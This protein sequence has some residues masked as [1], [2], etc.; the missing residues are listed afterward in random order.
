MPYQYTISE[1]KAF[2]LN[3][4]NHIYTS[5]NLNKFFHGEILD[6]QHNLVKST[7]RHK[8]M[9]GIFSTS[10]TQRFGKNKKGNIIYIQM[11]NQWFLF[12]AETEK[13]VD[14]NKMK[15]NINS[16]SHNLKQF[17]IGKEQRSIIFNKLADFF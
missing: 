7:I 1:N 5:T 16:D 6:Q 2:L 8:Y 3:L 15:M 11:A 12:V 4:E 13:I 17:E 10:Q 14:A 9:V